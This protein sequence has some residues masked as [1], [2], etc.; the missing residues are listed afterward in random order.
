MDPAQRLEELRQH[1]IALLGDVDAA[2]RA[3]VARRIEKQERAGQQAADARRRR[4][5]QDVLEL[6]GDLDGR[7]R[8]ERE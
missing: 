4:A 7:F 2:E 6:T 1:Y 3:A 5:A 8:I